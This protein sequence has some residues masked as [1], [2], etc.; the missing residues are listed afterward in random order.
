MVTFRE[1]SLVW[2]S[3]QWLPEVRDATK[4]ARS[5]SS[6]TKMEEAY[7][8]LAPTPATDPRVVDQINIIFVDSTANLVK[9]V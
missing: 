3:R 6:E 5:N 7:D 4:P 2:T 9:L 1:G 8:K